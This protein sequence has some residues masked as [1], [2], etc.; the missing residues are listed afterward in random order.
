MGYPKPNM[1]HIRVLVFSFLCIYAK[2]VSPEVDVEIRALVSA[3]AKYV[4]FVPLTVSETPVA[5]EVVV[6]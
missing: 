3:L 2:D 1:V 5:G 6:S 4:Q